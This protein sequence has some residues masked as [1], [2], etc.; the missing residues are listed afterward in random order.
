M[1][2]NEGL[3]WY[4]VPTEVVFK[5]D[6]AKVGQWLDRHGPT[7]ILAESL[8]STTAEI[9]PQNTQQSWLHLAALEMYDEVRRHDGWVVLKR[10]G[11]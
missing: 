2:F 1:G 3:P 4:D 10:V 9:A 6:V 8:E 11:P 7:F 5:K